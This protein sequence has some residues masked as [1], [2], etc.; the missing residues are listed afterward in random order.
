[1]PEPRANCQKCGADIMQI[2]YDLTEGYCMPCANERARADKPISSYVSKRNPKPILSHS[3]PAEGVILSASYFP[4][5]NPDLT[6]WIIQINK[7]GVLR[8]AVDWYTPQYKKVEKELDPIHLTVEQLKKLENLLA[9]AVKIDFNI[10]FRHC[11][12]DDVESMGLTSPTYEFKAE[13]PL[14]HIPESLKYQGNALSQNEQ[15]A[16]DAFANLWHFADSHARYSYKDHWKKP[17]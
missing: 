15:E 13:I 2:T 7:E 9:V 1:M 11:C 10:L 6:S 14:T 4:G 5:W 16:F 12:V 8:Q 3:K 17:K